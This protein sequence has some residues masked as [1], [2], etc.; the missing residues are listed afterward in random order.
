MNTTPGKPGNKLARWWLIGALVL[1]VLAL[2]VWRV[3]RIAAP[4]SG[5]DKS[6]PVVSSARIAAPAPSPNEPNPAVSGA[7]AMPAPSSSGSPRAVYSAPAAAP[8]PSQARSIPAVSIAWRF[9]RGSAL[10]V[11]GVNVNDLYLPCSGISARHDPKPH[12]TAK[13][14]Y[15][16]IEPADQIA[17]RELLHATA[18]LDCPKGEGLPV[19]M[20]ETDQR[21]ERQQLYDDGTHGDRVADDGL[22]EVDLVWDKNWFSN[23]KGWAGVYLGMTDDYDYVSGVSVEPKEKPTPLKNV[24]MAGQP[25]Q[26][27]SEAE[28]KQ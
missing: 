3:A 11:S 15:S 10:V 14:Y 9:T 27:T 12:P 24:N 22:W 18:I 6:I 2:A 20:F 21:E 7:R 8:A 4:V 13:L 25:G 28:A 26:I 1:A 5:Q 17:D 16:S 19:L 23:G